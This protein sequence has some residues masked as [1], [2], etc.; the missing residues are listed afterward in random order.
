MPIPMSVFRIAVA[1]NNADDLLVKLGEDLETA[2][3]ILLADEWALGEDSLMCPTCHKY[4]VQ[5]HS[6]DCRRQRLLSSRGRYEKRVNAR[7]ICGCGILVRQPM[8]LTT[9]PKCVFCERF[10]A[11]SKKVD[12]K[13][14]Y[15]MERFAQDITDQKEVKQ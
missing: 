14:P 12:K 1:R 15:P 9:P 7:W 2:L 6:D 11:E 13:P 4:A 5:G 10:Y 3:D 8:E